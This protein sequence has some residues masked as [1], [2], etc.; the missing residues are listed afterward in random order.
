MSKY[1]D[2]KLEKLRLEVEL[3]KLKI[4]KAKQEL[5]WVTVMADNE[6]AKLVPIRICGTDGMDYNPAGGLGE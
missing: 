4:E 5:R 3:M 2:L 1:E 6:E